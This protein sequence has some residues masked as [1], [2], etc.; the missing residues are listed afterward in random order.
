MKARLRQVVD[1][2]EEVGEPG[3]GIDLVQLGGDDAYAAAA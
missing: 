2:N 1:A 3:L